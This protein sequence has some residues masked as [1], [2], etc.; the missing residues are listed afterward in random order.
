MGMTTA[1]SRGS[2]DVSR[3][4]KAARLVALVR[5]YTRARAQRETIAEDCGPDLCRYCGRWWR[6]WPGS[7]LDGHAQCMVTEEFKLL[8]HEVYREPTISVQEMADAIGVGTGVIRA[9]CAPLRGSR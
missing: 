8:A 4:A 5:E 1:A 6:K 7:I 9:W 3:A 2:W